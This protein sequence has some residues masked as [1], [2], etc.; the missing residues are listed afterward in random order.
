MPSRVPQVGEQWL[1]DDAGRRFT[2][3]VEDH[4]PSGPPGGKFE[5]TDTR[6]EEL[7]LWAWNFIKIVPPLG[8][9]P[10]WWPSEGEPMTVSTYPYDD[11]GY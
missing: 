6:G 9:N 4:D 8:S 3:V 2:V 1:V 11:W 10:R 7:I 5:V